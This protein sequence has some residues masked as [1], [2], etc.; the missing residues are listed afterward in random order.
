MELH[1]QIYPAAAVIVP[2]FE[3]SAVARPVC[4]LFISL[5]VPCGEEYFFRLLTIHKI[6]LCHRISGDHYFF[7]VEQYF[8]SCLWFSYGQ[9]LFS[10]QHFRRYA[11]SRHCYGRF[12]RSVGIYHFGVRKP[13][14]ELACRFLCQPFSAEEEQLE[15]I[16]VISVERW[17]CQAHVGEGRR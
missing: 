11:D 16:K 10:L 12:C 15:I 13:F 5:P 7:S 3:I 17:V 6:P 8:R 2:V 14:H 1:L 9:R 4:S